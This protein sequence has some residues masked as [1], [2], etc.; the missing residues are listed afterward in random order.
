MVEK[1]TRRF[2]IS[3]NDVDALFDELK[4]WNIEPEKID[5]GFRFSIQSNNTCCDVEVY[6]TEQFNLEEQLHMLN[7]YPHIKTFADIQMEVFDK[8]IWDWK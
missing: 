1:K 7:L 3:V 6:V 5:C 8:V 4:K 2:Q